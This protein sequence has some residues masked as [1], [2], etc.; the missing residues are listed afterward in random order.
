MNRNTERGI[1]Y[2]IVDYLTLTLT[3]IAL[4]MPLFAIGGPYILK[5]L[6]VEN[7]AIQI[8]NAKVYQLELDTIDDL[9]V[10]SVYMKIENKS[11]KTIQLLDANTE[12][13]R[14]IDNCEVERSD[15]F[16]DQT[17]EVR[18]ATQILPVA[19]P[20]GLDNYCLKLTNL[21]RIPKANETFPIILKFDSG[22]SITVNTRVIKP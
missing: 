13:A 1:I 21:V 19:I 11:D 18:K 17:N 20:I 10:L 22:Q 7:S 9:T 6:I 4:L 2:K 16:S 8:S 14:D 15:Q 12:I 3:I 5:L